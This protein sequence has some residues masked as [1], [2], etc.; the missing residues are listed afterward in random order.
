M[1]SNLTP[2]PIPAWL[3]SITQESMDSEPF[4]LREVL[5]GSLY[6]PSCGFDGSPVKVVGGHVYS[7]IYVR[8]RDA[9][10]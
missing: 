6:Y 9:S 2:Q 3:A 5:L 4:P 10:E 1:N 7:F 8:D